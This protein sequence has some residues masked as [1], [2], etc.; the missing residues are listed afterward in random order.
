[1]PGELPPSLPRAC[2]GCDEPIEEIVC[3]AEKPTPIAPTGVQKIDKTPIA[4]TTPYHDRTEEQLGDNCLF[5]PLRP[6]PFPAVT[7]STDFPRSP[8]R[9]LETLWTCLPYVIFY[10]QEKR[11]RSLVVPNLSLA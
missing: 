8:A 7:S 4:L 5:Y 2:F 10:P 1:M 3:P 9:V 6:V 11:F